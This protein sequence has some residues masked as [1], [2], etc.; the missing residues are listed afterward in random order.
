MRLDAFLFGEQGVRFLTTLDEPHEDYFLQKL[1]EARVNC[2]FLGRVTKGRVLVDNMD[3][4]PI[5]RY[6][7]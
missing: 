5:G 1:T 2:C 3:F 7:E 6:I 4:G